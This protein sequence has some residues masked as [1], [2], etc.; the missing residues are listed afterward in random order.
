MKQGVGRLIR[1]H[2]DYGAIVL[3]DPRIGTRRYGGV[4]L[5]ALA[6]MSTVTEPEALAEFYAGHEPGAAAVAS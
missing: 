1:D 4:F 6:P 3:C 2:D 5:E